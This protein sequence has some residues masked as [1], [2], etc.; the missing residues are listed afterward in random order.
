MIIVRISEIVPPILF[1]LFADPAFDRIVVHI[2]E[3]ASGLLVTVF[4]D[5]SEWTLEKWTFAMADTVVFPGEDSRGIP[6]EGG[7]VTLPIRGET[8]VDVV[9]HLTQFQ[10]PD[11]VLPGE[12]AKNGK[13]NQMVADAVKNDVAINGNLIDVVDD[14]T[15]KSAISSPH[16]FLVPALDLPAL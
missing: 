3:I 7:Q 14:T 2:D 1:G 12:C 16:G 11:A 15:V 10:D 13:V 5:A 8:P 9:R 4:R 6:L